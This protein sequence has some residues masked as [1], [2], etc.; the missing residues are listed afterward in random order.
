[1]TVPNY[2][3]A[4][5]IGEPTVETIQ[6]ELRG[7]ADIFLNP[8]AKRV[9]SGEKL[10]EQLNITQIA[11]LHLLVRAVIAAELRKIE[12]FYD[13]RPGGMIA[14]ANVAY[15]LAD[16]RNTLLQWKPTWSVVTKYEGEDGE[17][18]QPFDN[19]DEALFDT[20]QVT[21]KQTKTLRMT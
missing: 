21:P 10:L 6:A 7:T 1:M 12:H 20:T 5:K 11:G 15:D 16:R 19:L 18:V 8:R 4:R 13:T 9:F 17:E 3:W 14:P 2:D